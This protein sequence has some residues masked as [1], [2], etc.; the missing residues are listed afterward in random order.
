M[1]W[2]RLLLA[3]PI[4]KGKEM[5]YVRNGQQVWP[6]CKTCSRRLEPSV[7]KNM[8]SLTHFYSVPENGCLDR[9]ETFWIEFDKIAHIIDL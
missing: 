6:Y 1:M 5:S 9:F 2:V 8:V 3:G 4:Y 7:F